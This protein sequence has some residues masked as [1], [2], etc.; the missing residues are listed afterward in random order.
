MILVIYLI[1]FNDIT[2]YDYTKHNIKIRKK[3]IKITN[4]HLTFSR[5]ENNENKAISYLINGL[6]SAFVFSGKIP[7]KYKGFKVFNGDDTDLRFLDPKNVIIGL[8]AK[9]PAK[10]DNT[11]FVIHN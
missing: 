5:S 2:Y 1:F 7:T 3:A 6:N 9:G 11:G 4:Y 8:L 10:K